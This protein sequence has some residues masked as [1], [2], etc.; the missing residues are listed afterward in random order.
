MIASQTKYQLMMSL[1]IVML[2]SSGKAHGTT[3]SGIWPRNTQSEGVRSVARHWPKVGPNSTDFYLPSTNPDQPN[4]DSLKKNKYLLFDIATRYEVMVAVNAMYNFDFYFADYRYRWFQIKH[5]D[6][7]MPYFLRGLNYWWQIMPDPDN[8][9][10][11]QQFDAYMDT[12]V[13]KAE[14]MYRA[15]KTNMEAVFFLAAAYGFKGRLYSDRK[16][17]RKATLAGRSAMEYM[18]ISREANSDD[19][20]VEFL[21]GEGLYNYFSV[22]VS[23]NYRL[24][25]PVMMFFPKGDKPKG[26][27]QLEQV[28]RAAY[29]TR[30][31][32]Q[33]FVTR[34]YA[35]EE[36]RPQDAVETMT[37][38]HR[39]FPN[40]SF[41]HRY[42]ARLYHSAG[43][44][45]SADAEAKQI[46]ARV[47]SNKLG[48]EAVTGRYG[49]F[50]LAYNAQF[51]YRD[52]EKAKTWYKRCIAFTEQTEDF[53]SGYYLYALMQM[54]RMASQQRQT[55]EAIGYYTK[56]EQY[57]D[58]KSDYHKEAKKFLKDNKPKGGWLFGLF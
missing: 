15:D 9:K 12:T 22:W 23:E 41:F 1:F 35:S 17:W 50:I 33:V 49:S 36:K 2:L 19:L 6:H 38:L 43:N 42:I 14:K 27:A 11:D 26:L 48:Y 25:R 16:W 21:F 58:G 45:R 46:M 55:E 51:N 39:T 44:W 52:P 7:P 37:Y 34:I 31:E 57:S 8:E 3:L 18:Q 47:D 40:N 53:D 32:A 28:G 5:P 29:Y 24:L 13:M 56:L 30:V 10:Y 20:G 54:G 4:Q